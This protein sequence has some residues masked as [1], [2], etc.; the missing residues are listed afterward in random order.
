MDAQAEKQSMEQQLEA[1][2]LQLEDMKANNAEAANH[3]S[4]LEKAIALKDYE[5][6]KLQESNHVSVDAQPVYAFGRKPVGFC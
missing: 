5:V 2:T 4:T 3:N 1:L 6:A